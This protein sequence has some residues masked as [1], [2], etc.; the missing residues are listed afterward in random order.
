MVRYWYYLCS[1]VAAAFLGATD[2]RATTCWDHTTL[3]ARLAAIYGEQVRAAVEHPD[4][5]LT[6]VFVAMDTG[7]WTIATTGP[8]GLTCLVAS[9]AGFDWRHA[10]SGFADDA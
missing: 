7:S 8:D 5:L 2:A 9:G 4:G 6:E 1:G 3:A 10:L